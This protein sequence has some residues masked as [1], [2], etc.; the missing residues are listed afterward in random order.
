MSQQQP[1]GTRGLP[2]P[3]LIVGEALQ[4]IALGIVER[5]DTNSSF[6]TR[7]VGIITLLFLLICGMTIASFSSPLAEGIIASALTVPVVRADLMFLLLSRVVH[8][9][10]W[11]SKLRPNKILYV[12]EVFPL[13]AAAMI[14]ND[15]KP[16]VPQTRGEDANSVILDILRSQLQLWQP[17]WLDGLSARVTKAPMFMI[18]KI[19]F[20]LFLGIDKL[21]F[22]MWRLVFDRGERNFTPVRVR[23]EKVEVAGHTALISDVQLTWIQEFT[24]RRR[25]ITLEQNRQARRVLIR[26]LHAANLLR[27]SGHTRLHDHSPGDHAMSEYYAVV[28]DNALVK[29]ILSKADDLHVLQNLPNGNTLERGK[30]APKQVLW[31]RLVVGSY[32]ALL[33]EGR[34]RGP[35]IVSLF[36]VARN[37]YEEWE[38]DVSKTA[39]HRHVYTVSRRWMIDWI[40]YIWWDIE[41][42]VTIVNNE[43]ELFEHLRALLT[44]NLMHNTLSLPHALGEMALST[45]RVESVNSMLLNLL[46]H[47]WE[48]WFQQSVV[49]SGTPLLDAMTNCGEWNCLQRELTKEISISSSLYEPR[50]LQKVIDT[51]ETGSIADQARA[52]IAG[53]VVETLIKRIR[54]EWVQLPDKLM[55]PADTIDPAD[56][57]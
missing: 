35:V 40:M 1:E 14:W 23:E 10:V 7:A 57:V 49:V 19:L 34:W 42:P 9:F 30:V 13:Q 45:D 12:N 17:T 56:E 25:T 36:T 44:N 46:G 22:M 43:D 33:G 26:A 24:M 47:D 11:A 2:S 41:L 37:N 5:G 4:S 8:V 15:C 20:W 6:T 31:A 53:R 55:D 48:T 29:E 39:V 50:I 54:D 21:L 3:V 51:D 16:I 38:D 32:R 52:K 28:A 18:V 27:Y